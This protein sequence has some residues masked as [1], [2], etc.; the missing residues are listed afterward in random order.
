M[1]APR[2]QPKPITPAAL[3]HLRLPATGQVEI[4]DGGCPGL[5]LRLST[6]AASWVL[7]CRDTAGRPRRFML[8]RFPQMGL[9]AA[10]E[11]AQALRVRV[12][13][14]HDPIAETRDRRQQA[15]RPP[16][17]PAT[18]LTMVLD[19]YAAREGQHRRSW[20][21][22]RRHVEN[23]FARYL[24]Q[25]SNALVA[26]DLQLAVD[27]WPSA[28][29]AG[30][31][32]RTLRPV[33]KWAAKRGLVSRDAAGLEL[34]AGL[35]KPRDRVLTRDEIHAVLG[36]LDAVGDYGHAIRWLFWTACRLNEACAMCWRD[37]DLTTGVWAI[38]STKTNRP[39][40]VP[41]PKQALAFLRARQVEKGGAPDNL[42]FANRVG[43]QL[44]HWDEPTKRVQAL[45]HTSGWHRHDIRRT[46]ATLMAELGVAPHVIEMALNHTM[47]TSSDGS[48]VGR[49]AATYNRSRYAADH[50]RALQKLA[51]D[52]DT[53]AAGETATGT[54]VRLRA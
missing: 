8:G 48:T 37:V 42:V 53:I 43:R 9:K 26:A 30:A 24:E 35:Y 34:P 19:A 27:A 18:T 32:V 13:Q 36:V 17:A 5:R 40:S 50:A 6:S 49:I 28:A 14:G 45:S 1:P 2:H 51:D 20:R 21:K 23:V 16:E 52:F 38:P 3:R 44:G 25:P 33:L 39:H 54:V 4:A 29:S 10:R 7:G 22:S 46:G 41:L 12:R 11:A 47:R 15:R 31:A